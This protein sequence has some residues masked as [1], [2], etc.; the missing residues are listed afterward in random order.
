MGLPVGSHVMAA[1]SNLAI[2]GFKSFR[3]LGRLDLG[4]LNVLIG[5]NGSGKSNF[6]AAL[7]LVA[8]ACSPREIMNHVGLAG[9]ANRLLHYGAKATQRIRF[10][11]RFSDRQA[12]FT[13]QL[14]YAADDRLFPN[15]GVETET[16]P[17][18]YADQFPPEAGLS[19]GIEFLRLRLADWQAYHFHDT[20]PTSPI[21]QTCDLHDN[22][23]LRGDGANLA[24]YLYRLRCTH[25]EGYRLI[26][27]TIGLVAPFFETFQ[28][29]PSAL[30]AEKLQIEWRHRGS[31]DYFGASSL[32][33]GTLRF[34]ALAALLLQPVELRPKVIL[35]DEPELGLHPYAVGL[36]ASMIRS[37]SVDTQVIVATQSPILLDHFDPEEVL[38]ADR[39]SGETKLRR[40]E[41]EPLKEWLED[42]SLGELWEK[43]ELGGRPGNE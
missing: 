20:S 21:R 31:D 16:L 1:I 43:N 18:N 35:I 28:L 5:A 7:D 19:P 29:E 23:H 25:Q 11:V 26:C 33:D 38:V 36:L 10:D 2:E 39:K 41:A 15:L 9:G 22:R 12:D 8:K 34:M 3:G 6:L 13:L 17:P 32:S 30:N 24:A 37:A 42:Y 14:H 27:R 4:P 40:L